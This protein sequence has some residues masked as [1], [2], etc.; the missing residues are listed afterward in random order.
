MN[1]YYQRKPK[2]LLRLL[3]ISRQ[4]L[5]RTL[6]SLIVLITVG[7]AMAVTYSVSPSGWTSMPSSSITI[8]GTTYIAS[9][10]QGIYISIKAEVSSDNSVTFYVKKSSGTFQ[11]KANVVL[12]KDLNGS[13]QKLV[14][15]GSVSAGSSQGTLSS[16]TPDFT[17]GS[18]KYTALL[19]SNGIY[20]CTA[21]I[22]LQ[23]TSISAPSIST[24]TTHNI[25]SS[26]AT[27]SAYINPNGDATSYRFLWGTSENNLSNSSGYFQLSAGTTNVHV[28]YDITGLSQNTTYYFRIVAS[29]SV[30]A[31][32][33][34]T[35]SFTTTQV[36]KPSVMTYNA[37]NVTSNSATLSG[38]INPNGTSAAYTFWWGTD[39]NSLTNHHDLVSLPEGTSYVDVEYNLTGLSPN[40]T[41]YYNLSAVNVVNSSWGATRSFTTLESSSG[42]GDCDFPDLEPGEDFY[43]ETCYLY[44]LG[45]ISGSDQNGTMQVENNITRGQL[46]KAAFR[47]VYSIKGRD[48]DN[49]NIPSDY[50]PIIY[51]DLINTNQDYSRAARALLYLEYGDGISPFNRDSVCF[52]PSNTISRLHTLK[53]LLETF[54]IQPDVTGTY[55]PFPNDADVVSLAS[56]N[57]VMMGYIRTA[58][59]LG[60]ITKGNPN[61]LCKRGEAFAMLA[62]IM[63]KVDDGVTDPDP[64]PGDYFHP[65][66]TTL[67]TIALGL[68]LP[69]GNFNHYTKS[70]FAINGTV[71]L[72]F[73]HTYNS[74]STTY[75]EVFYGAKEVNGAIETYQPLGDGWSHNFHT[76]VRIVGKKAD[77]T[78]R[79]LVHWGGGRIDVWKPTSSG[80]EP[81]SLGVYDDFS[82]Q[83]GSIVIKTKDQI[84]YTFATLSGGGASVIYLS[85]VKDRNGN[86]MTLNYETGV[87]NSKRITRVTDGVGNRSL[88]FS[89]KSGTNLLEKVTDPLGRSIKFDYEY[90]DNTGRYRLYKFTDAKNQETY[91]EYG[92]DSKLSTSKLLTK[93]QLPKGNY[94]ENEYDANRRLTRT[95]NGESRTDV[96]I[97]PHYGSSMST[98]SSVSVSRGGSS[99][100][101]N[102]TY[103]ENNVVTGLTGNQGL[104]VN[105]TYGNSSH[106]EL[107][108]AISSNSTNVSNVTYDSKGNVT[109]VVVTGDGTLSTTM[110]YDEMNNLTSVTD[111]MNN[112][113][114]Y[115]YDSKGN[116]I[117]ISAPENVTTSI[118][119]D[120]K[121]RPTAVTNAMSVRTEYQYDSY[122]NVNKVILPALSLSSTSIYDAA[123]RLKSITDALN[124]TSSFTYDKN[125]NL[126]RCTDPANNYT[127]YSYDENDNLTDITNA[128]GGVTSMTYDN[129]TDWLTSISFAGSTKSYSYNNDGTLDSYTKPDGNTL[130]YSYDELGR[131]TS[132]GVNSYNYDSKMRLSSISGNGKTINYTYDGFNR[133]IGTSYNGH[134]NSYGYDE[135]SNCT[136]INGTT[137]NYD[138]LNRLSSVK[139]SG[140]TINYTYRKDSQLQKVTYPNGMTTVYGYD[141]VG[142]LT[143]KT[144]KL[145]NGTV[146][147]GYNYTLDNVGNITSQTTQ[148]PYSNMVLAN[149]NTSYTYNSGNR[150]TKA[151][152]INFTFDANGN[153][154]KRGTEA[155]VWDDYDRLTRAGSTAIE[156]DP[157]GLIEKYGNI[158]FTTDPLG[159]GNV[160]SDSKSGAEYIY[161]N[162]LEARVKNG[163]VSYYVTDM[164]GSV[165]AIVDNNGNV[166]HKY[167][168]DDFGRVTQKQEA[169]YN[170]FQYVGKYGV[171]YLNDH[172]YYMRARHYD[173][174]IGRFLSE[175][176]IWNTNLYPYADNNPIMGIDPIGKARIAIRFLQAELIHK[177][178]PDYVIN[179]T[180]GCTSIKLNEECKGWFE[181]HKWVY[182]HYQIFFDDPK[183]HKIE[184]LNN[185]EP[186]Y[187]IGYEDE[188]TFKRNDLINEPAFLYFDVLYELPEEETVQAVEMNKPTNFGHY[189]LFLNNCQHYALLIK[190]ISEMI[191]RHK[192]GKDYIP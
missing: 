34:I 99:S 80:F 114:T 158:T 7:Q 147:A 108:T 82:I 22:T 52:Y 92:D 63:Q 100:T 79:V 65:L 106:P 178:W 39:P 66:N 123:S 60:I 83:G 145:S 49:A 2:F 57:P 149:E 75:P 183:G 24:I 101:Y 76:F 37:T 113:T 192:Y 181:K 12:Y 170:P 133:V 64:N 139:F 14:A 78:Q 13:N 88:T 116:L 169:D 146:I 23:A 124:R 38:S 187:N 165:V 171:M 25:T 190:S 81:L 62:R 98:N 1:L 53:V 10:T 189:N 59:N 67:Q 144:T 91:Y 3:S 44:D 77:N 150:I 43:E 26:S 8:N 172:Q 117:G 69:L 105:S 29:N 161:G 103:N 159:M 176:P 102:Y 162:G 51:E 6:M 163:V 21:Q 191:Y 89:Y 153:T 4:C 42:G 151:G 36:S 148:E 61:A 45:V 112:K 33:S 97:Q 19:V 55:N 70:S 47:G 152:D 93:I 16:F 137:Y 132:D 182:V 95:E 135:N 180:L 164:R 58:A 104:F 27:I 20:F 130:S 5:L 71:P 160:L 84:T 96:L 125:D 94:I 9:T 168:Y 134:S 157:L 107:P 46:A 129:A 120:S 18:Y 185:N 179:A 87:N 136:S 115:N 166:T 17:S 111:P 173:P 54:N 156:Y 143:S 109:K 127:T 110:T 138:A 142:R 174:T 11:N 155:Y 85:S 126:L 141:A 177:F 15:S 122:G 188:K 90:I 41:Y 40:T 86:T 175:D 119:V 72:V 35:K 74:Y 50:F 121:G 154:T 140:N 28:E 48:V 31:T 30:D 186:I 131:I 68:G 32:W 73:A 56:K 184:G 128:K 167:Q 118:T